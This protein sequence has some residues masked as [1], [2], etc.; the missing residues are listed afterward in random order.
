[1]KAFVC[2]WKGACNLES[3]GIIAGTN[4]IVHNQRKGFYDKFFTGKKAAI[5]DWIL[6]ICHKLKRKN[7]VNN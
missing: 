1:M 2:F 4:W 7:D 5:R 3:C 6:L